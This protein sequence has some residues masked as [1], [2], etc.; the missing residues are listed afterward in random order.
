MSGC[1]VDTTVLVGVAQDEQPLAR[2]AKAFCAANTPAVLPDYAL[3]ELMAGKVGILCDAHNK[4]LASE[5]VIEVIASLLQRAGFGRTQVAKAQAILLPIKAMFGGAA[6][7]NVA[8][9]KRQVLEQLMIAANQ[10]WRNSKKIPY[11]DHEQPLQCFS[12]GPLVLTQGILK[13]PNGSFSCSSGARCGAAEYMYARRTDIKTMIKALA[14]T[15]LP[16]ELKTKREISSRRKAL[17][18]LDRVGPARFSKKRCRALGDAYFASMCKP[19]DAV[20]TTNVVDFVPLCSALG[21]G[22]VKPK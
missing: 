6:S 12:T 14:H 7:V 19:G 16:E 4:V 10:L 1:I 2:Q 5:N 13:G 8:D 3:R 9:V 18:E 11:F 22:V 20:L 15:N 21:K 17:E